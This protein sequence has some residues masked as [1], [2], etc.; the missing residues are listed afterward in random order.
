MP[1]WLVGAR[2]PLPEIPIRDVLKDSVYYPACN[3]DGDPIMFLAGNFLSFVYV[4]YGIGYE[5]LLAELDTFKGYQLIA[6]RSVEERELVPQGWNPQYFSSSD[7]NPDQHRD[8]I[9]LSFAVWS[10]YERTKEYRPDHGPDRFSL[11]YIGNDAVA[12]FQSLYHGNHVAPAVIAVMQPGNDF[13]EV[14]SRFAQAVL[15]NPAGPPTFLLWGGYGC[16]IEQELHY[17]RPCWPQ[18]GKR[19]KILRN[20]K[21]QASEVAR[22]PTDQIQLWTLGDVPH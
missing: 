14:T 10:I 15:E 4:D 3:V 11:L 7:G 6:K 2:N 5:N 20:R 19:V 9:N 13:K 17:F 22:S 18:Y 8:W 16:G 12:T 1:Q 21:E